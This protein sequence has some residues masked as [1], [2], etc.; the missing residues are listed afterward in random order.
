MA[1]LSLKKGYHKILPSLTLQPKDKVNDTLKVKL[2]FSILISS[3]L[4]MSYSCKSMVIKEEDSTS[5]K[6][7]KIFGRILLGVG[8]L[9]ISETAMENYEMEY[10]HEKQTGAILRNYSMYTLQA[11][12]DLGKAEE[13]IALMTR[14]KSEEKIKYRLVMANNLLNDTADKIKEFKISEGQKEVAKEFKNSIGDIVD[15]KRQ[16]IKYWAKK[17]H[18]A[19]LAFQISA[20]QKIVE[21]IEKIL[22]LSI[23]NKYV[24][25]QDEI[26]KII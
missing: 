25:S 16:L 4:I 6:T 20:N 22:R 5:D 19:A 8:T 18:G 9:G 24:F 3:F 26:Y 11:I 2:F 1:W 12:E 17:E 7:G 15:K 21:V 14:E 13:Q 10:E 23:S